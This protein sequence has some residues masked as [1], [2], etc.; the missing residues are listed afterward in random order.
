MPLDEDGFEYYDY[1]ENTPVVPGDGTID[2]V[3]YTES[4]SSLYVNDQGQ[5]VDGAGNVV[6]DA[7]EFTPDPVVPGD[8]TIDG[9]DYSPSWWETLTGSGNSSSNSASWLDALKKATGMTGSQ[10]A[11]LGLGGLSLASGVKQEY[12]P[13]TPTELLAMQPS[14]APPAYTAAQM[15]Q[16]S[17]PFKTGTQLERAYAADMQSPIAAGTG[18]NADGTPL[19]FAE[20]GEVPGALSQVFDSSQMPGMV[21]GE[22]GGQDDMVEARLSPGE[23]VFDAESVAMLG[24]GDNAAGA[25]KLDELRAQLRAHKRSAPDDEIAPP[26]MGP[27]S[28]LGEQHNG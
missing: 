27:L 5:I 1:D 11:G 13:K 24:D 17:T 15:A 12:K 23:Y 14:N 19:K 16:F 28:Y 8:G 20:G 10:L 7:Q 3:D 2:G 18:I 26:A 21:T 6:Q 9:V 4:G 25:R 22:G